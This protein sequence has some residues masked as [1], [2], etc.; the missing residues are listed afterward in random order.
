MFVA[1]VTIVGDLTDI[2]GY[3]GLPEEYPVS[4]REYVTMEEAEAAHP[5]DLVL[6][7]DEYKAYQLGMKA[8][9]EHAQA[10]KKKPGFFKRLFG[11]K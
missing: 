10:Q 3:E 8:I 2:S 1:I 11:A 4:C 7:I 5:G 6:S 9:Y